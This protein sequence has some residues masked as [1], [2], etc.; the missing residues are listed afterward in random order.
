MM[1]PA[2]REEM[3]DLVQG[4]FV[5]PWA[6]DEMVAIDAT[7]P[8]VPNLI[9]DYVCYLREEDDLHVHV[10]AYDPDDD[11]FDDRR[12]YRVTQSHLDPNKVE[13]FA[14]REEA[15]LRAAIRLGVVQP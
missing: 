11:E 2:Q 7:I 4:A 14:T 13:R 5:H 1:T 8:L 12:R 15:I 6:R 10:E 3:D 9:H